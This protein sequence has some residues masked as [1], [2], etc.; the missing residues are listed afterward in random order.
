MYHHAESCVKRPGKNGA[1]GEKCTMDNTARNSYVK[2][3]LTSALLDMLRE[4]DWRGITVR[5]LCE[6]AEV[7]RNSF[8][9]NYSGKEDIL[10][11]YILELNAEW[12]RAAGDTSQLSDEEKLAGLFGY[13][14]YYRD[15]YSLLYSRG[16][17]GVVKGILYEVMGPKPEHDN[18][19]AYT[20]AFLSSGIYGWIEEW[21]A[22]GMTE[23]AEE[24]A[25]LLK[26]HIE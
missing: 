21:F 16:L 8:Y 22:R 20:L 6:R 18:K 15:F 1:K 11:G 17:L 19:L 25:A 26:N 24:M 13:F 23:S 9:R 5:A 3:R 14:N 10:R 2:R 4:G 7:S 12:E